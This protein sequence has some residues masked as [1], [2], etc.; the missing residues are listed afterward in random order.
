[1]PIDEAGF[2]IRSET[3]E[4]LKP[5]KWWDGDSEITYQDGSKGHVPIRDVSNADMCKIMGFCKKVSQTAYTDDNVLAA[6]LEGGKSYILDNGSIDK[7]V[8][9]IENKL[10]L[11]SEE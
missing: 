4:N 11:Y 7:A 6:I 10:A 3:L 5:I 9:A 2:P 8:K 1:M